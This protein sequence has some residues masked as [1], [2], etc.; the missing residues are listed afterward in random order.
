MNSLPENSGLDIAALSRAFENTTNS[1]KYYW[2]LSLLDHLAITSNPVISYEAISMN[3]LSL[4][5]YPLD[6]YK[7]SF[8]PADSFKHL[9]EEVT[10]HLNVDN[11]INAPSL[12]NQLQTNL[13]V[14][15]YKKLSGNITITLKR[16]VAHRFIRPF[17][18]ASLRGIIDSEINSRI[19]LFTQNEDT[20]NPAL[21]SFTST[22][23]ILT[24]AWIDYL[25]THQPILRGFINWHL[26]RFLQKHNPNV[27]GLSEKLE[28][29]ASRNM[30]HA[31]T[32]WSVYLQSQ[33]I[34]CI[35][36]K[37]LI[38][39][40]M[41]S[42]DH[43]IPWSYMA[44]DQLWNIIPTTASVNSSKSNILPSLTNYLAE[45]CN[46]QY[47]AFQFHLNQGNNK[48]IEDYNTMLSHADFKLM[49]REHFIE[50]LSQEINNNSRIAINMGF[51]SSYVYRQALV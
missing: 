15:S 43:F 46:L 44:H 3:M 45:F 34:Q 12:L 29:P 18:T 37:Q 38:N 47:D 17:F 7:L 1:Y 2:F 33:S 10:S 41:F 23:I 13:S 22:G 8:G 50:K 32:Y 30:K 48:L 27:I 26:L 16:F 51:Q 31:R 20:L 35:Y 42:L 11:G 40:Q 28:K 9:A 6:F 19:E 36:S 39:T 4:V 24:D 25:K 14:K 49:S 21:Y 5:W